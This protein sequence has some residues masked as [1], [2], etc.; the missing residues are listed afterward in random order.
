MK[1]AIIDDIRQDAEQLAESVAHYMDDRS[2]VCDAPVFY[3]SGEDF[4]VD[5]TPSLYDI[6]FLDIYMNELSGMETAR[7]IR[8]QDT[9]CSI[10]FVTT[11]PD[12]AVDSY[13]VDARYYLLKPVSDEQVARALDRCGLEQME[14][15]RFVLV[16]SEGKEIRLFLHRI[17][18]TEYESRRIL[19]HMKD[20][21]RLEVSM[22]QRDFSAL[23]LE[24]DCFCDCMKGV[25]VNFEDVYKLLADHFVMKSG[26]TIPISRLK[27]TDV[28][29]KYLDYTFRALRE[30]LTL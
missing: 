25:L 2:V 13:D 7:R 29:E 24:H 27:Y 21:S 20:G 9:T 15:N 12:F 16:P 10:I 18:Y 19:V 5:F 23:L 11:S 3:A 26:A 4:L 22:N 28:R 14:Q 17:S 30:G 1:I 8:Q 6:V